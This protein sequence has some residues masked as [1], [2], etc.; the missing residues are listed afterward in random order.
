MRF[1]LA[2]LLMVVAR[3]AV[4]AGA[5]DADAIAASMREARRSEGFEVRL[6]ASTVEPD[7]SRSA[8]I[9]L[10][11]VGR[12][13]ATRQRL[14]IRGIAPADVRGRAVAAERDD[15]GRLRAVASAEPPV[16]VAA[17]DPHAPL[18]GA[19]LVPWDMLGAW[20]SWPKQSL[21]G[22]ARVGGRE[23]T[24]LR[25]RGAGDGSRIAEV[26]SCVDREARLA[27]RTQLFAAQRRRVRTVT[28]MQTMRKESGA[29]AAKRLS[30]AAAGQPAI[31]VD[32][33]GGDEHYETRP[34]TFAA[35]DVPAAGR[36]TEN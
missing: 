29:S 7:G 22:M 28:V 3:V 4:A 33:Y 14:V 26:L 16:D 19:G 27:R 5:A 6:A 17:A 13:E 30:I 25:S 9:R 32:V 12:F 23:C 34:D 24:L 8:Q 36:R 31:E 10:A 2:L 21:E 20:W 15:G 1:V 18:F 11:V 35:L